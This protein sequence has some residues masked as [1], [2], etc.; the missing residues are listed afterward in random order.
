[1]SFRAMWFVAGWLLQLIL[2]LSLCFTFDT[3]L[4][5]FAHGHSTRMHRH[6]DVSRCPLAARTARTTSAR[7]ACHIGCYGMLESSVCHCDAVL[8]HTCM[9]S[10][11]Y[12]E[13]VQAPCYG[14]A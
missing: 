8:P 13:L 2:W 4:P 5:G 3:S 11:P 9:L 12:R 7:W 6:M 1:M 14:M 10:C